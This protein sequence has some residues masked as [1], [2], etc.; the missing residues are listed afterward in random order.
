[1]PREKKKRR[2]TKCKFCLAGIFLLQGP[3]GLPIAVNADTVKEGQ[4]IY[5]PL[6]DHVSHA[7]SCE[8]YKQHR[9][10]KAVKRG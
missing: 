8:G 7:E 5:S 6:L 1:M 2:A 10:R 9:A 3:G 4:T